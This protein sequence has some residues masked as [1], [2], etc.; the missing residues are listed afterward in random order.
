[1]ANV[2]VSHRTADLAQ[3]QQL[4]DELR[5]KGHSIWIDD[6]QLRIGDSII[7]KIDAGLEGSTYLVLCLS[8]SGV[9]APWTAREWMATLAR[10]LNGYNVRILPAALTGSELPAILSDIKYADLMTD[11]DT[12]VRKLA[13]AIT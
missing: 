5:A 4:A 10:Q 6:E 9:D 1:M 11:W 12:G 2:F 3:A 7:E 13:A 8:S